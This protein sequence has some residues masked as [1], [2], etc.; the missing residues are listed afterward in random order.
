MDR[1]AANYRDGEVTGFETLARLV[2]PELA[3]IVEVE[4]IRGKI[5]GNPKLVDVALRATS[6][7]RREEGVWKVVHRHADPITTARGP[8]TLT[9]T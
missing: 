6:V 9:Q 5:G 2:T 7:L 8:E 1:A 3:Y 4:R